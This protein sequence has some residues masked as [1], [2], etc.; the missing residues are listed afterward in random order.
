MMG[1]AMRRISPFLLAALSAGVLHAQPEPPPE[2]VLVEF[3]IRRDE[4]R[5]VPAGDSSRA[6]WVRPEAGEMLDGRWTLG[7]HF[8]IANDSAYIAGVAYEYARFGRMEIERES[9]RPVIR[10]FDRGVQAGGSRRHNLIAFEKETRVP[11]GEFVRGFVL[12]FGGNVTVEGEVN[13][14][15]VV[16]GGDVLVDSGAVVR[17]SVVA[18]GGNIHKSDGAAVYGDVFAG[19]RQRFRPR[20]FDEGESNI[21]DYNMALDYNRVTGA[22]PWALLEVGPRDRRT[23]SL[24]AE[25]GYAFESELWHYRLSLGRNERRGPIILAGAY[26]DTKNDDQLRIGDA[27]N[28]IFALLFRHDYRDYYFAEGFKLEGGWAFGRDRK[29]TLSYHNE[30]IDPLEAHPRLWSLFG[31]DPFAPNYARLRA[32]NDPR[33]ATDFDG[34]LA[35]LRLKAEYHLPYFPQR[36]SGQW[37]GGLAFETSHPDLK[38]DFNYTRFYAWITREQPLWRE[39]TLRGRVLAGGSGGS[40]PA[41]RTFYLGGIGSLSGFGQKEFFGERIWLANMEY[42]WSLGSWELLALADAG[43]VGSGDEWTN[44]K[45][46]ADIGLGI[47]IQETFRIQIAWAVTEADRDPL[48][49]FRFSRPF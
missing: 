2:P 29:V 43:Q 26:R 48:V 9:N 30:L 21:V 33:L 20:I 36:A 8:A 27:E 7:E 6:F 5:V 24:H 35:F 14:S 3:S 41:F 38:S 19:N 4:V 40:L 46:H 12:Q 25:A 42:V 34:R 11:P 31:G 22:L 13:R 32:A 39:Q 16:L 1:E 45:I 10:I 49:T 15:V 28:L 47:S 37:R 23:V 44:S 17:G 18:L